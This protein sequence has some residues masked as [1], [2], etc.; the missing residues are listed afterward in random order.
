MFLSFRAERKHGSPVSDGGRGLKHHIANDLHPALFGFARQRWRAWIETV[1]QQ[2]VRVAMCGSPVSDGGRELKLG[3]AQYPG[4][5]R[6]GSPVSD[7]GRG[8]KRRC[9]GQLRRTQRGSPV[10]DGGRG[11]KQFL[12]D[13]SPHAGFGSPVSDGGRGLKHGSST[14]AAAH[15]HGVRPSAMAGVD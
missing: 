5:R 11:L 10:S 8:L 9:Q 3:S 6:P 2:V 1:C 15:A 14:P 7:G 12:R 4:A 13:T